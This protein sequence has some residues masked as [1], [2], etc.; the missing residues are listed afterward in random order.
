MPK[1]RLATAFILQLGSGR[2]KGENRTLQLMS[3]LEFH[4]PFFTESL[5]TTHESTTCKNLLVNHLSTA[6][7]SCDDALC[8][9]ATILVSGLSFF[10]LFA[11]PLRAGASEACQNGSN[12]TSTLPYPKILLAVDFQDLGFIESNGA[13]FLFGAGCPFMVWASPGKRKEGY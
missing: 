1:F 7:P 2:I 11:T 3:D 5:R 10:T 12:N 6:L 8:I 4:N 9:K 13:S